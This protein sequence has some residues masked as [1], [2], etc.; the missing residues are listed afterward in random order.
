VYFNRAHL[1]KELGKYDQ[2]EA[3]Y[4]KVISLTPEDSTA[5]FKRGEIRGHQSRLKDA[6]SDYSHWV[7]KREADQ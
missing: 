7:V 2:A 4:T 3:D 1:Y 5:F 6:M